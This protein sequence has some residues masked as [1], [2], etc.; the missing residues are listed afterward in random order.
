MFSSTYKKKL[1]NMLTIL[2]NDNQGSDQV[3]RSSGVTS[4]EEILN[5]LIKKIK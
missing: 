2:L 5:M 1:L 3:V 4:K